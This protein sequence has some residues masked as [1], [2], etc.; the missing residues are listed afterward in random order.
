MDIL[1]KFDSDSDIA[2]MITALFDAIDKIDFQEGLLIKIL[3]EPKDKNFQS[4]AIKLIEEI[5]KLASQLKQLISERM[6]TF[7]RKEVLGESWA[8]E[9]RKEIEKDK[10]DQKETIGIK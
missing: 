5:K 1:E 4:T 10:L 7:F 3:L 6:I 2:S 9:I 8:T